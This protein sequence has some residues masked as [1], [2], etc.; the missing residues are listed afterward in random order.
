MSQKISDKRI[1]TLSEE[2]PAKAVVKMGVPL[3]A[4]M[5]IMVL[6]N[7]VDTYFIG[8]T[9][10]DYQLAAVNLAY[11]VMMVMVALSNMVGTGAS[12]LIARCLGADD[13]DKAARTLTAGFTLTVLNSLITAAAGLLFLHRI[14]KG[15][16]AGDNTFV[17]TEQY[18]RIILIG[19]IFT[20]GN[21]SFGQFLRSEGSVNHSIVGMVV[22][23][24]VNMILDPIFIFTLGMQIRGAALATV[25]G[26]AAGMGASLLFYLSGKTMLRPCGRYLIPCSDVLGEIYRVGLPASLETLL[27]S[28]AYVVN[29]NLAVNYGELTVAAMGVAQKLLSLGNYIYQGFAAGTQPLMGY[30]YGAKNYPRMKAILRCGVCIVTCTELALMLIYGI[31]APQLIGQFTESAKVIAT[32]ARV[33]R[34]LMFILP[35]VG[36]VSMCRMSFQAMG[37][38]VYA[39]FITLMRQLFLYIP[40][41]LILNRLFGLSGMLTAQ[42]VTEALMMT[43]S[44]TLLYSFITRAEFDSTVPQK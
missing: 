14:V 1:Y 43:A 20:M 5:F 28:A 10:D 31:F 24:I 33:L 3:I 40:L 34:R 23:T 4:G 36:S 21:Y 35:F 7:L 2:K 17:Y 11:P 26:N 25:I 41:L 9:K 6:Y 19:S 32:G 30:N 22:G 29:N 16:G 27:S 37:K 42:P 18:V 15:L 12:S 8:L 44:I 13:K 39:F 38:P